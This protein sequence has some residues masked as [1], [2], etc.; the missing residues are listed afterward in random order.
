MA[1]RRRCAP[2][3]WHRTTPPIGL[4]FLAAARIAADGLSATAAEAVLVAQAAVGKGQHGD[5]AGVSGAP[6]PGTD[7][8][9]A[10]LTEKGLDMLVTNAING[11]NA[12]PARGGNPALTDE[13]IQAAVEYMLQ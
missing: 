1:G 10:R 5:G 4:V 13:Q 12:M 6:I 11:I 9:A 2:Q 3:W 7:Q 8:M